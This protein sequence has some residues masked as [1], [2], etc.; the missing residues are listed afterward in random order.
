MGSSALRNLAES[1]GLPI[2]HHVVGVRVLR[3]ALEGVQKRASYGFLAT[4]G[5]PG[6]KTAS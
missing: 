2:A 6:C 4:L 1:L 3:A 5:A